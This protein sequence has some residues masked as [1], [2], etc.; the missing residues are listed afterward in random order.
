M[1]GGVDSSVTA[2]LLVEAGCRPI[3][4]T[5]RLHG[6]G[7]SRAGACCT[8][9]DIRDARR[10]ADRLGIPHYV[11][12]REARFRE[13]VIDDFAD[14]YLAGRTPLPCVRCNERVKFRDLLD[15]ALDLGAEAL[16]TGHYARRTDGEEG[17]ELHRARDRR[18]DQSYFL[19]ATTR[20]QLQHMRLPIGEFESKDEVRSFAARTGLPVANKPDSQDICFVSAGGYADL[21]AHHRSGA[22]RAGPILHEDGTQLGMHQGIE[23]FTVGQRRGLGVSQ[24]APLFVTRIDAERHAVIVGPRTS[25]GATVLRLS[26]VNWLGPGLPEDA[27][28]RGIAVAARVRSSAQPD[29]ATVFPLLK[30]GQSLAARVEFD[31]P[32]AAPAPGQ[33]CVFYARDGSRLLGGG[34]IEE[35]GHSGG[36]LRVPA[37]VS[38]RIAAAA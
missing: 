29:D 34:W 23:R 37:T 11:L 26:D 10:V 38:G 31:S 35:S 13:A 16:A 12:D 32:A 15:L 7:R 28:D 18:R 33:A 2:A 8:G 14:S 5:L 36:D 24:S 9:V 6:G 3:G 1:S 21:V 25:L 22:R 27:G 20:H 4:V 19:F 17:P 30:V